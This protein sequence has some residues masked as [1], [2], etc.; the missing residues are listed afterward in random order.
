MYLFAPTQVKLV[1][2]Q[3]QSSTPQASVEPVT[4]AAT[5][6]TAPALNQDVLVSANSAIYLQRLHRCFSS[7]I[8]INICNL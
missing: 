4:S 1:L 8:S 3:S 7:N 2:F 5:I 6:E